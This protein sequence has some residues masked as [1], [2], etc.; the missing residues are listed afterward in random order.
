MYPR[1]NLGTGKQASLGLQGTTWHKDGWDL[2]HFIVLV[3]SVAAVFIEQ[4]GCLLR[5]DH[6]RYWTE[7][8]GASLLQSPLLCPAG[9]QK[10]H[11]TVLRMV[12]AVLASG[13]KRGKQLLH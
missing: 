9:T 3:F 11:R 1:E 6:L 7:Q 5:L 10:H 13:Q 12:K 8:P 2:T 4:T